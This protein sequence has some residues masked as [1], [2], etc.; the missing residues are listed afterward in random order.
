V[1]R[2]FIIVLVCAF[3]AAVHAVKA[4]SSAPMTDSNAVQQAVTTATTQTSPAPAEQ[5]QEGPSASPPALFY[6]G[7][8]PDPGVKSV[9]GSWWP[10]QLALPITNSIVCSWIVAAVILV[11]VR[12]T[13]P[14]KIKE[15]PSGMQNLLETI[16]EGWESFM[17]DVLDDRVTR[18]VFPFATTFLIFIVMCNYVDL[19]PGVGSIGY[20]TPVKDSALPFAVHDIRP[21]LFRPPTSDPNLTVA[22]TAVFLI[23]SLYWA[24]RYNGLVGFTKHIF[25]VKM[26]V[27]A[28]VFPI[29]AALFLFI[30][31][32][33]VVSILFARPV[34]LAMRLYGNVFAGETMLDM[35]AQ[36]STFLGAQGVSLIV[37]FYETFICLIQGFVFGLLVVA[38]VGTMCVKE[39]EG[40]G[41]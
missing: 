34:A 6:I 27:S 24:I 25:G 29:I 28:I 26:K 18:W 20:G 13:T 19:I 7:E 3:F 10:K 17:T 23:M 4:Q 14:K 36:M 22:M 21:P 32:M 16:V 33:E 8:S 39:E 38:F 40:G 2:F 12:A 11:M 41:H 35:G 30:G 31:A 9:F 1:K 15:I 37:Y 5:E